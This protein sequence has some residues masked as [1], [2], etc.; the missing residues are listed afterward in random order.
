MLEDDAIPQENWI[1][2][3]E[4]IVEH[5][6]PNK[7]IWINLNSGANLTRSSSDKKLEDIDFFRVKPPT[8]SCSTAYLVNYLVNMA[9]I[10]GFIQL[11]DI[12]GLPAWLPIDVI[13]Q[14]EN[15]KLRSKSYWAE[16]EIFTQGSESGQY[17]SNLA[18]NRVQKIPRWP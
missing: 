5:E 1:S 15:R 9:Y 7:P 13:F 11:V 2:R 10:K 14:V 16:P 17:S 8:T 6:W 12:Y 4:K 18:K 3:V